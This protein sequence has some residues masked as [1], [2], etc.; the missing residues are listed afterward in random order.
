MNAT[1]RV[2]TIEDLADL[3][4]LYQGL[5]EEMSGLSGMWRLTSGLEDPIDRSFLSAVEDPDTVVVI[6]EFDGYAFGFL[7]ATVDQMLSWAAG[8]KLGSIRLVFVDPEAREVGVGEA[9]REFVL[10]ELRSR[11]LTRFDAHVLPGH[12]LAKNFFEQG[13]FSARHIVMHHDDNRKR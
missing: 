1:A 6:G 12:R 13:G 9:M 7:V 5:E 10:A 8:E 3:V 2:A 11:G 4:G